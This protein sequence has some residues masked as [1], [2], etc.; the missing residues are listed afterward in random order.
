MTMDGQLY[1]GWEWQSMNSSIPT[2]NLEQ[3]RKTIFTLISISCF[4]VDFHEIY[5][6]EKFQKFRK[7]DA[8]YQ[9]IYIQEKWSKTDQLTYVTTMCGWCKRYLR[10]PA[11]PAMAS[12]C[13][14][15]YGAPK[16][17]QM[18]GRCGAVR[19]GRR[20]PRSGVGAEGIQISGAVSRIVKYS[21]CYTH[22]SGSSTGK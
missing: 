10:R 2:N 3:R 7:Q 4:S 19:W 5:K 6:P 22:L 11:N 18:Q 9:G 16:A 12:P 1:M 17:G 15:F 8:S 21:F 14:S 13:C 20:N